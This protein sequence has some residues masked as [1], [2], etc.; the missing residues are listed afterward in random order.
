MQLH[1]V[2]ATRLAP[3]YRELSKT[4]AI[5]LSPI[6]SSTESLAE[7]INTGDAVNILFENTAIIICFVSAPVSRSLSR[8]F[9]HAPPVLSVANMCSQTPPQ[10]LWNPLKIFNQQVLGADAEN[11]RGIQRRR[12]V[13]P[14]TIQAAAR[15]ACAGKMGR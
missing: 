15:V 1:F 2:G 11:T 12:S 3:A 14:R 4:P 10:K 5:S 7:Q 8:G 9:R 6:Q 13:L